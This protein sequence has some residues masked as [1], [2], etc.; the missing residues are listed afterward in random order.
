MS[1]GSAEIY[2][3][4]LKTKYQVI[5]RSYVPFDSD[6]RSWRRDIRVSTN[7]YI[8]GEF[9]LFC[10]AIRCFL[11]EVNRFTLEASP[12]YAKEDL[13][14]FSRPPWASNQSCNVS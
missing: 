10:Q 12:F 7:G 6:G 3:Y 14:F 9:P 4:R 8:L 13:E 5:S 11:L 1:F 2:I